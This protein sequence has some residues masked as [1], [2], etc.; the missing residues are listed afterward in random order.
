[1]EILPCSPCTIAAN[2]V[3]C[4][5]CH[6]LASGVTIVASINQ[7]GPALLSPGSNCVMRQVQAASEDIGKV[8]FF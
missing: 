2:R 3:N 6:G 7:K 1:M 5:A 8:I 4:V